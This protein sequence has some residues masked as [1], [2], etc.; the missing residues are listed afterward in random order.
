MRSG[1]TGSLFCLVESNYGYRCVYGDFDE[2]C[3]V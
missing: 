3:C 2:W 1:G